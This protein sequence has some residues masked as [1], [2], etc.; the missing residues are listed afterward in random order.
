MDA[1]L[2]VVALVDAVDDEAPYDGDEADDE[3][4]QDEERIE[5]LRPRIEAA[6]SPGEVRNAENSD[7]DTRD[8]ATREAVRVTAAEGDDGHALDNEGDQR[9]VV[10]RNDRVTE[11][12]ERLVA[13]EQV[14]HRYLLDDAAG[15]VLVEHVAVPRGQNAGDRRL[16]VGLVLVWRW[17]AM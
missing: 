12:I 1:Q 17:L 13:V 10:V 3:V 7:D 8:G 14:R 5:V 4:E 16:E 9:R 2:G 15:V 11:E 6:E